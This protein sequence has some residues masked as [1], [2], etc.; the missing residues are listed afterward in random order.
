MAEAD[1]HNF[2]PPDLHRIDAEIARKPTHCRGQKAGNSYTS[3]CLSCARL[4][5]DAQRY[6][7]PTWR[8]GYVAGSGIPWNECDERLPRLHSQ[9]VRRVTPDVCGQNVASVT[10]RK[11]AV[12]VLGVAVVAV[13]AALVSVAAHAA[14]ACPWP[15]P[16]A[17]PFQGDQAAAVMALA[18][19]PLSE[20]IQIA[21]MVRQQYGWRRVMVTRDAADSGRLLDLRSMNFGAGRVCAGAV[22]RSM[23]PAG[24]HESGRAF[25][26]GR[27]TVVTFDSC[28][29][30]ALATDSW[31]MPAP[32]PETRE[33][34]REGY[35][36][37][38][39]ALLAPMGVPEPGTWALAGLALA[40]VALSRGRK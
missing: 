14:P 18:E 2:Q 23:W 15:D 12:F 30:V 22:D 29:N 25:A 40:G 10:K 36:G 16:G 9:T 19:I 33:T 37:G 21:D 17:D 28:R 34:V 32:V 7:V 11:R 4:N 38:G 5:P 27:W 1:M 31:A 35:R 39:G 26:V 20:R 6:I 3:N 8:A 13:A 24:R